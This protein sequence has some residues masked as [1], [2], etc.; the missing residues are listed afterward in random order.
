MFK[1][2]NAKTRVLGAPVPQPSTQGRRGLTDAML[3]L[4]PIFVLWNFQFQELQLAAGRHGDDLKNTKNEITELTRFIQR[5]RSEIENAKKQVRDP[6]PWPGSEPSGGH[7]S[8]L[9]ALASQVAPASRE[10]A[11]EATA[12]STWASLGNSLSY[13]VQAPS[14]W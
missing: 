1:I 11:S 6:G 3:S 14:L 8:S 13:S 10:D 9:R 2:S 5:L 12:S 4:L 7:V